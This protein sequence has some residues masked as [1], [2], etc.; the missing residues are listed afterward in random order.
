MLKRIAAF[1]LAHEIV[2]LVALA[3]VLTAGAM[4]FVICFNGSV[5]AVIAAFFA[6]LLI[7]WRNLTM[8]ERA[9][10]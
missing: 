8:P 7:T 4:T 9:D 2:I 1:Y 6:N 5:H 10:G 3:I